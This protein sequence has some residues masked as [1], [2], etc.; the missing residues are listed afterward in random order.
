MYIAK[1]RAQA[2]AP[3]GSTR[4]ANHGNLLGGENAYG[5]GKVVI[6]PDGKVTTISDATG[7]YGGNFPPSPV[8]AKELLEYPKDIFESLGLWKPESQMIDYSTNK[9]I[10]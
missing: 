9:P 2:V 6:G 7:H 8:S 5:A 4:S 3:D 1:D 10:K